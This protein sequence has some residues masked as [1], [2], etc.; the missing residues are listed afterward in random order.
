MSLITL[1]RA[2]ESIPNFPNAD[3]GVLQDIINACSGI[4]ERY[5]N[6][7]FAVTNYDEVYD[8]QGYNYL[9]LNQYPVLS[10]DR[11]AYSKVNVLQVRNTDFGNATAFVSLDSTN[12]NLK[13]TRNGVTTTRT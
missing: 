9:R 3:D 4:I 12:L 5:T 8:G 7:T 6:V 11:V 13:S 2:K 10:I 1:E